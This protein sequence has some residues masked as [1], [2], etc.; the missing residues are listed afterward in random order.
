MTHGNQITKKDSQK[1]RE[2]QT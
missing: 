1:G 2:E